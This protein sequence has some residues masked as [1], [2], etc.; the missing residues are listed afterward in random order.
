MLIQQMLERP[1]K[2]NSREMKPSGKHCQLQLRLELS[3]LLACTSTSTTL[4]RS[5]AR[6]KCANLISVL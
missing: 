3:H 2:L 1:E 4:S 6:N 5:F